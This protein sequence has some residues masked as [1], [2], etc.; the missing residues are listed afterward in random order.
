M[1]TMTQKLFA[2][3]AF[4]TAMAAVPASAATI[5]FD[6]I[7]YNF[8]GGPTTQGF[9]FTGS[10]C[11]GTNAPGSAYASN[12][13]AALLYGYGNLVVTATGGGAFT[14]ANFLAGIGEY[15]AATNATVNYTL[16]LASGGTATGSFGI[17][18]TYQSI[19]LNTAAITSATFTGLADGYV[20][21]D[22]VT[23]SA[24]SGAVPE[25]ATW[26]LMILGFGMIGGAARSRRHKT[27]VSFA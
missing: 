13:T 15:S 16:T 4:A 12:G 21:F 2:A 11:V 19:A 18:R 26:G 25:P 10:G 17:D 6:A 1:K 20:A 22:N 7:P 23:I 27:K 14:I 5:T 24:G 3:A 8:C 9:N